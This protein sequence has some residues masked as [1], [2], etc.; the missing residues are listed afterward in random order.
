VGGRVRLGGAAR[1]R[2]RAVE[3]DERVR[4]GTAAFGRQDYVAAVDLSTRA[5]D[6]TADPGLIAFNKAA[7]LYRLAGQPEG[8][9]RRLALYRDAELHYRRSLEDAAR[10]RRLRALYGLGNRLLPQGPNPAAHG[11]RHPHPRH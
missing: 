5:E 11:P 6:Q 1:G 10:Q 9:P 3:R 8:G 7:A 4:W 2:A